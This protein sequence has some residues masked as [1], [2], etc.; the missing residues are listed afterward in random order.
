MVDVFVNQNDYTRGCFVGNMCQELADTNIAIANKAEF[1]FR[2]YTVALARSIKELQDTCGT[3]QITGTSSG[4]GEL[5]VRT[6]LQK[7]YTVAATMRAP[8][9]RNA[10]AAHRLRRVAAETPGA[11]YIFE[12]DVSP[13]RHQ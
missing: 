2:R 5:I 1:L 12:L 9:T 8:D 13:I 6:L 10:E 4:F 11:L 3:R 7:G